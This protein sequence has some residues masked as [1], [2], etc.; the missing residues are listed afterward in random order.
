MERQADSILRQLKDDEAKIMNDMRTEKVDF[1]DEEAI[2]SFEEKIGEIFRERIRAYREIDKRS[3][4]L[5]IN[6]WEDHILDRRKQAV[7]RLSQTAQ[8]NR[9]E[10]YPDLSVADE[11]VRISA[12]CDTLTF[13]TLNKEY[14]VELAAAIWMLDYLDAH[15][16]TGEAAAHFP[17]TEEELRS[18]TLPNLT[19]AVH[20]DDM[21][22]AMKYL[23]RNR[24]RGRNGFDG[25]K[26]WMDAADA[27]PDDSTPEDRQHFD[28]V[29][30]L[31]DEDTKEAI[32][33]EFLAH[34][35][36]LINS[37]LALIGERRKKANAIRD[38]IL[39]EIHEQTELCEKT[40]AEVPTPSAEEMTVTQS[41]PFFKVMPQLQ[42]SRVRTEAL[43]KE[44][45]RE[46]SSIGRIYRLMLL[47]PSL[48]KEDAE[49]FA[50]FEGL[51][52]RRPFEMCFA[53]LSLLDSGSD[54]VW[55]YNLAYDVL[56]Y[57][58]QAL[59]WAGCQVMDGDDDED[60][61]IDVELLADLAEKAPGW[62][63]NRTD[64]LLYQKMIRSPLTSPDSEYISI[65]RLAF[66]ST[67]LVPPRMN[68]GLA[69]TKI[70]LSDAE[71]SES[72]ADIWYAYIM[73]AHAVANKEQEVLEMGDEEEDGDSE[74]RKNAEEEIRSLKDEIKNLRSRVNRLEHRN[75]EYKQELAKTGR[76][77]KASVT[78]LSELRSMIR[79]SVNSDEES[80]VSVAFPYTSKKRAVIIGGHP[81]W[82]NAV[83]PL[84]ENVRFI[85]SHEQ[86][87]P[88]VIM[89]AEVVWLQTNALGHSGYYKIIDIIRRNNIKVCYFS[90]ASA[91]KCA[92]QFA[93]EDMEDDAKEEVNTNP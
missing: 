35:E 16:L 57:A 64:A 4:V 91:E 54:E 24:N 28:A 13:D 1:S 33:R 72:E 31:I 84:L 66:L 88:G 68:D 49:E 56:A 86:P 74:D 38:S 77:L 9:G 59:P 2:A 93:L 65:A 76:E 40:R 34:I 25:N 27:A 15:E 11:F 87:H 26:V 18:M 82:V 79:E 21:L 12:P 48:K 46:E 10:K 41:D 17:Q 32:R 53:F 71:L 6:D 80:P 30:A 58:C 70:L 83:K 14:D 47:F 20:S 60:M 62:D 45:D 78:E 44:L 63:E 23:I 89:N 55:A 5:R 3:S 7:L 61:E 50:G 75:R 90:Y 42:A 19:D 69:F 73:L 39:K 67:G 36:R 51:D 8:E 52:I 85:S 29:M 81:S 37:L 22:R 92:E 43:L